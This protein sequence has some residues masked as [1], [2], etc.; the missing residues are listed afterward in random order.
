MRR[1]SKKANIKHSEEAL[2]KAE[3]EGAR[4]WLDKIKDESILTEFQVAKENLKDLATE[5]GRRK[6]VKATITKPRAL[7]EQEHLTNKL[8]TVKEFKEH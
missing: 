4:H 3:T 7:R 2:E 8:V 1:K 5:K 6:E